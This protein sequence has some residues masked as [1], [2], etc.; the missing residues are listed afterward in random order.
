MWKVLRFA[1]GHIELEML[2]SPI[3]IV[4]SVNKAK[5]NV[6]EL[7]AIRNDPVKVS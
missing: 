3:I 7:T 2:N 1:L 4:P 5:L 6:L